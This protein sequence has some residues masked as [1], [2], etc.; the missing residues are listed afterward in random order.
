MSEPKTYTQEEVDKLLVEKTNGI[1]A[2]LTGVRKEKDQLKEDFDG[3]KTRLDTLE[4]E[5]K[6]A[7]ADRERA[8]HESKGEYDQALKK[9]KDAYEA[10]LD[11]ITKQSADLK[12]Q[13]SKYRIDNV[14]MAEASGKVIDGK[15]GQVVTLIKSDFRITEKDDGTLE[16]LTAD[17]KPALNADGKPFDLKG[18]TTQYLTDNPHL[19]KPTS[20][21]GSGSQASTKT[22]DSKSPGTFDYESMKT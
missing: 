6:Q 1:R 12:G 17:G 14:I 18:L 2:E 11:E 21:G 15:A 16:I 7:E 5:K 8:A 13:L 9:V 20:G 4:S 22:G 19:V 3:L 10:K